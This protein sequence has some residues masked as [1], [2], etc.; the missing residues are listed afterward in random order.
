[1]LNQCLRKKLPTL[2]A[3]PEAQEECSLAAVVRMISIQ[4]VTRDLCR[5]DPGVGPACRHR[6]M[7]SAGTIATLWNGLVNSTA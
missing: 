7:A 1:M 4:K 2:G 3:E 5:I 6:R